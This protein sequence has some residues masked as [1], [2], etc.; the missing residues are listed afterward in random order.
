MLDIVK[1]PIEKHL[2]NLKTKT[3]MTISVLRKRISN[4][5]HYLSTREKD[6]K[7]LFVTQ[8]FANIVNLVNIL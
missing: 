2:N 4:F 3:Q 7:N 1:L 6:F 5:Q 8:M